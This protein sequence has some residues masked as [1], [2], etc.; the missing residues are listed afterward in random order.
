MFRSGRAILKRVVLFDKVRIA[1]LVINPLESSR[2]R[3]SACQCPAGPPV[4]PKLPAEGRHQAVLTTVPDCT[5][6][7]ALLS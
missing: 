2:N 4:G 3:V 5:A 1:P 7:K 6:K